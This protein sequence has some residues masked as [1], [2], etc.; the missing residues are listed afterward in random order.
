VEVALPLAVTEPVPVIVEFAATAEPDTNATLAVTLV[1]PA[2]V[3]ML[4]VL[5][6]AMVEAI[7][8][9]V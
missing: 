9:V 8:P 3:V 6:S 4:I 7:V 5:L 2:G 1:K